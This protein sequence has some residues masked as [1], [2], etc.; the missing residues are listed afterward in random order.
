MLIDL[1]LRV[2]GGMIEQLSGHKA[3]AFGHLGTHID[4]GHIKF[5]VEFVKRKAILFD[6]RSVKNRDIGLQDV[7]ILQVDKEMFVAFY[8]GFSDQVEYASVKYFAEHPQLAHE[9]INKLLERGVSIIGVDCAGI[10]RAGEHAPTDQ[11]CA[12][13]GVFI[14]ENLSNMGRLLRGGK[15]NHFEAY[16]FPVNFSGM[17]GLPCR[18]VGEM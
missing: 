11:Y 10:R 6:V 8:T 12:E 15:Q 16:T 18:V 1:T 7:D 17:T 3:A 13:R 14:V 4:V 9:L 2:N 5:P